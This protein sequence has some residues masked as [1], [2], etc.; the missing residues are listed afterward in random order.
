[1]TEINIRPHFGVDLQNSNASKK[2]D[3]QIQARTLSPNGQEHQWSTTQLSN[4]R[5]I[6]EQITMVI[7]QRPAQKNSIQ[8]TFANSS[9]ISQQNILDIRQLARTQNSANIGNVTPRQGIEQLS[10]TAAGK[11]IRNPK[12]T[13]EGEFIRS[14]DFKD[15]QGQAIGYENITRTR[16]V[17]SHT[18]NL[19]SKLDYLQ[20]ELQV[21]QEKES[22]LD[23]YDYTR[24][25]LPQDIRTLSTEIT[26]TQDTIKHAKE[27]LNGSWASTNAPRSLF[28]QAYQEAVTNSKGRVNK[29]EAL[30]LGR[31]LAKARY[32]PIL[33][34]LRQQD[35]I[36]KD[37]VV[38]TVNRSAALSDFAHN[39]TNLTEMEDYFL[40]QKLAKDSNSI[41]D[42]DKKRLISYYSLGNDS[43]IS[44]NAL[45]QAF[46][47]IKGRIAEAYGKE[48]LNE[49]GTIDN[50]LLNEKIAERQSNLDSLFL[51]DLVLQHNKA[52]IQ[53]NTFTYCRQSLVNTK[54]SSSLNDGGLVLNERNQ[55]LDTRA[56]VLRHNDRELIYDLQVG[57]GAFIHPTTGKIHLSS[58]LKPKTASTDS[59]TLKTRFSNISVSGDVNN[60][61]LQSINEE[62]LN[63]LE[64]DLNEL[65]K[66]LQ[67]TKNP[68]LRTQLQEQFDKN[69]ALLKEVKDKLTNG[70]GGF[71]VV[72][73]MTL[74]LQNQG[75]LSVNCYGGKDR[76][77]YALALITYNHINEHLTKEIPDKPKLRSSI[78]TRI[79]NELI[80]QKSAA[81]KVV[82]DNTGFSAI[83]LTTF[84]LKL[85]FGSDVSSFFR[86][87]TNRILDY[88]RFIA[89]FIPKKEE[90]LI[91]EQG[92]GILYQPSKHQLPKYQD[93]YTGVTVPSQ[94]H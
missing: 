10:D 32:V 60:T 51:Q 46:K 4:S 86:Q 49:N 8:Q 79:G 50:T 13:E 66:Q 48:M 63:L 41:K 31:K 77:G 27:H 23:S 76:T 56:A 9:S 38:S 89:T 37:K 5:A 2:K 47:D 40:L 58:D 85:Y 28:K 11:S 72:E 71:D 3:V 92:D 90:D 14:D 12:K 6:T 45:K 80:S 20:K 75:N 87:L 67:S 73:K 42:P 44:E 29:Q 57:Q 62:C 1:M 61:G 83:K 39:E 36:I 33:G 68:D 17:D 34:N 59:L 64:D 69:S 93:K 54:R 19:Q 15:N 18:N 16:T 55:A 25:D 88:G 22:S 82:K 21:L 26:K 52:K 30:E 84:N 74:L 65:N 91:K 78:M 70:K 53:G 81:L 43:K 35:V 94:D 7:L 24:G